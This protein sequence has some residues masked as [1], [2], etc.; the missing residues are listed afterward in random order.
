MRKPPAEKSA[1]RLL[2][3]VSLFLSHSAPEM[4]RRGRMVSCPRHVNGV[5]VAAW[6]RSEQ[7]R[8]EQ[9]GVEHIASMGYCQ[10]QPGST[11]WGGLW[12]SFV[13]QQISDT[14]LKSVTNPTAIVNEVISD[15]CL[16]PQVWGVASALDI[17]LFNY[18]REGKHQIHYHKVQ[19]MFF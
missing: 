11:E 8:A 5:G 19:Y 1:E 17:I 13:S 4:W 6:I 16:L 7:S 18:L 2:F 12:V 14:F 15:N 9:S 10:T 3:S